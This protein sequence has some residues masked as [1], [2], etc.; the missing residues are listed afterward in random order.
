MSCNEDKV[1]GPNL[2]VGLDGVNFNVKYYLDQEDIN[3]MEAVIVGSEGAAMVYEG[4]VQ[5]GVISSVNVPGAGLIIG[6]FFLM[7]YAAIKGMDEGCGV[8]VTI[9]STG[10]YSIEPQ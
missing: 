1:V 3:D 7:N 4:L 5:K 10:G 8:I 9:Y 6:G 2:N